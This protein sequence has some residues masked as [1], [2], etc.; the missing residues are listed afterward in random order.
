MKDQRKQQPK[1]QRSLSRKDQAEPVTRGD[2][3]EFDVRL[4]ER[5]TVIQDALNGLHDRL[6]AHQAEHLADQRD[7]S[8]SKEVKLDA[9][10]AGVAS[11]F[12]A[13]GAALATIIRVVMGM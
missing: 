4:G 9:K 13:A 7:E 10:K 6:T 12:V 11:V 8:I 1:P 3:F 5:F 2:L